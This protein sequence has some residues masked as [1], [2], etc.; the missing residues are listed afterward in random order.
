M[1]L[2]TRWDNYFDPSCYGSLRA[3]FGRV[4]SGQSIEYRTQF[5]T[6]TPQDVCS[7][8]QPTLEGIIATQYPKLLDFEN[9]LRKKVGPMSIMRPLNERI[10]DIDA[11][12]D[13]IKLSSVPIRQEAQTALLKSWNAIRGIRLRSQ[14]TTLSKMKLSTNSGSPYFNRRKNAVAD[15]VPCSVHYHDVAPRMEFPNSEWLGAAILGWRGQEGGPRPEDVKQ[16]V[17]W[18]FP[19]AVNL[20]ELQFYQ[21]A[22]EAAQ[23]TSLA[24]A[25]MGLDYVDM[26]IT[27]M[28]DSKR[29]SDLVI[30]TDF[31]R[32]DQHFNAHMQACA[33]S[34][35]TGLLTSSAESEQ[36]LD[37]VFPIKY[38]IPLAIDW[39]H[40]RYG[41][42]GMGSGS[43]GTNWDESVAHRCLQF[44]AAMDI[45]AELNPYSMAQGDDGILTYPGISVDGIVQAY[46]RHGQVCN[47]EKQYAS[48][49]DCT[50]LRRW[51]SATYRPDGTCRGVYSTYRAIGRLCEQERYYNP[52]VWGPKMIALRQLSILENVKWHPAREAFA[53]FCMERDKYRLGVDI[54][55]FLANIDRLAKEATDYMPDFLGYTRSQDYSTTKLSDWWIVKYLKSIA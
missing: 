12:Y 4:R 44:E 20:S 18:M 1:K 26:H 39:N 47:P 27:R 25:W 37:D 19:F 33:R 38:N 2:A 50:F 43:G 46:S 17:V 10:P 41:P 5:G 52:E 16:R 15:T 35:A 54:P 31:K 23:R 22:I 55:D 45:D 21:P 34:V 28:F 24:P 8:W 29:D 42:H 51:Y 32:F 3:Y 13:D 14:L 53:N 6:G 9:D 7:E 36:W 30:C 48:T 40:M 49:D 11:Y